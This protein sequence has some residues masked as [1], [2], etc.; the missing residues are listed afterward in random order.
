MQELRTKKYTVKIIAPQILESQIHDRSNLEA[1]DYWKMKKIN[2][3]LCEGK[4]Y[5][6][7]VKAGYFV[8]ISDEFKALSL[9]KDD[10]P[11]ACARAILVNT[12]GHR[13]AGNFYVNFNKPQVK[14]KLFTDRES[15][16]EWLK[17]QIQKENE[18][19]AA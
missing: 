1:E 10:C 8:R 7:L 13:I 15:A 6:V 14:T 18:M 3:D 19:S 12:L 5:S 2:Q 9:E 4:V 16:I 11:Q 17:E